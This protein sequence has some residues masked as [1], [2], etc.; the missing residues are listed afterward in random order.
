[1]SILKELELELEKIR[2]I[3][4]QEVRN[5]VLRFHEALRLEELSDSVSYSTSKRQGS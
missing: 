5:T 4:D 1:M 3:E 2:E